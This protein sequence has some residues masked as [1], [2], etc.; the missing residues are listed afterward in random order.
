[1]FLLERGVERVGGEYK[2]IPVFWEDSLTISSK[3][4]KKSI[5]KRFIDNL[6]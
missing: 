6:F 4:E 5:L 2:K 3:P 1:M